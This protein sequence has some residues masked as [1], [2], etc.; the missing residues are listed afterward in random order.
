MF[1]NV[2]KL[3]QSGYHILEELAETVPYIFIEGNTRLLK[4]S[5]DYLAVKRNEWPY[6]PRDIKLKVPLDTL[7]TQ[8]T[9]EGPGTDADFV[10]LI[11][12]ATAGIAMEQ[13][14]QKMFWTSINCL[15]LSPYIA[16]RWSTSRLLKKKPD[17][18]VKKH[19]F[20]MGTE[21]RCWNASA[22]LWWLGEMSLR[23]S[24]FSIHSTDT[25]LKVMSG[26]GK[27]GLYHQLMSRAY[28]VSNP[29]LTAAIYD[30]ALAGNKYLFQ[31]DYANKLFK[32]L[33]CKSDTFNSL[34][35]YELYQIVENSL[36]DTS[37]RTE[38]RQ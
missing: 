29:V 27:V 7:N 5:L 24:E 17:R 12:Q 33:R 9:E 8:I 34:D 37:M 10:P 31:T 28:A 22:R 35:Y 2:L 4:K 36:P 18:F 23:A 13:I 11:R 30:T 20:W 1:N 6:D 21:S 25:L 32:N 38:D 15:V 16:K 3:N 19:W 14:D 26:K